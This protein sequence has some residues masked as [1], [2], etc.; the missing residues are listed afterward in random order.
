MIGLLK[1]IFGLGAKPDLKT[2]AKAG[3]EII[4]VRT[5]NE[6]QTGYIPGSINIPLQNLPT[7]LLKIKKNR[8]IITCCASGIRSGSAKKTWNQKASVRFSTEEAGITY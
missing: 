8:V 3:A 4:D 6:F 2:L 1:N 7:N 5:K